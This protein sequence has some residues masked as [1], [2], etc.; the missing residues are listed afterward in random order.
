MAVQT[1]LPVNGHS[2]LNIYESMISRNYTI[3]PALD[4]TETRLP[5]SLLAIA[6]GPTRVLQSSMSL[7]WQGILLEKHL[8]SPGARQSVST[9]NHVISMFH[10][11][12]SRFE[13]RSLAGNFVPAVGRQRTIMITPPA[14]C[15]TS[16]YI[17]GP[18]LLIAHSKM[19][20]F[21]VWQTN[22]TTL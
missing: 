1:I 4:R 8:S 21:V 22:W 6:L 14:Q 3:G 10:G 18:S 16:V 9:D 11:S 17:L 2:A 19:D 13:H 15:R 5:S 12:A 20:S 7:S